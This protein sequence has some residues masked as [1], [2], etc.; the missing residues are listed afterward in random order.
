MKKVSEFLM[1]YR[2]FYNIFKKLP[3]II[4]WIVLV[5]FCIFGIVDASVW[6]TDMDEGAALVVWPLVGVIVGFVDAICHSILLS[7]IV[8]IVDSKLED[9]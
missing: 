5:A 1:N 8:L 3:V 2:L 4:F 9:K 7:P 6:I